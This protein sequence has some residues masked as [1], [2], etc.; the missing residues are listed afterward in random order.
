[1]DIR[2]EF[3]EMRRNLIDRQSRRLIDAA[4]GTADDEAKRAFTELASSCGPDTIDALVALLTRVRS[5]APLRIAACPVVAFLRYGQAP[6]MQPL[7][8][9]AITAAGGGRYNVHTVS[10]TENTGR[11]DGSNGRY[12][13]PWDAARDEL[14]RRA[15]HETQP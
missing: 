11:W 13:V 15:D 5:V 10:C 8:G 7:R 3:A 1:M 4:G 9:V 2:E 6:G 14:N 12:G